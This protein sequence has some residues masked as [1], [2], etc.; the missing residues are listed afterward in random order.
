MKDVMEEG[1]ANKKFEKA[2]EEENFLQLLESDTIHLLTTILC[3]VGY[4]LGCGCL[5][6]CNFVYLYFNPIVIVLLEMLH[7]RNIY[8]DVGR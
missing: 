4:C 3:K 6:K 5:V 2:S 8:S 7:Q 1:I